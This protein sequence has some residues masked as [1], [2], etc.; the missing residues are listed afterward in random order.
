VN[1]IA[2]LDEISILQANDVHHSLR[3]DDFRQ[4]GSRVPGNALSAW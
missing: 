3:E 2:V 1:D 4:A